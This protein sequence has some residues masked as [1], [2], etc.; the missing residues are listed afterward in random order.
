MLTSLNVGCGP[1]R[2]DGW[3]NTDLVW[4]AD[5]RPDIVVEPE[6]PFPF[7]DAYLER[8]YLGHV[9]EHVPWHE[10]PAW[11]AELRRVLAPGAPVMFVGP[12]ALRTIDLYRD[13]AATL[14]QVLAVIEGTGAYLEH[15]GAYEPIRWGGDRHHWNCYEQRVAD[16]L[17]DAGFVDVQPYGTLDDGRLDEHR[18]LSGGWP[19]V[20]GS[21]RQFAVEARN[22]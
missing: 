8:A 9:L 5:I 18:I 1:H 19:L 14:A 7:E 15:L 17:V 21:P 11:L 22:P 10:V 13:H 20:D 16:V 2:A 6:N 12:D 4:T 3:V